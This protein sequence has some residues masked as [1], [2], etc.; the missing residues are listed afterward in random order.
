MT[1][2]PWLEAVEGEAWELYFYNDS[3]PALAVVKR[4]LDP[5]SKDMTYSLPSSLVFTGEVYNNLVVADEIER[6]RRIWP[7]PTPSTFLDPHPYIASKLI[8]GEM[9]TLARGDSRKT[10]EGYSIITFHP[11]PQYE[12]NQVYYRWKALG[13]EVLP[14]DPKPYKFQGRG[15][16]APNSDRSF[17]PE[18]G[19]SQNREHY[20]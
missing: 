4:V 1:N 8:D 20:A 15:F 16:V 17:A 12:Q 2:K 18:L 6:G 9:K 14:L 13:R 3:R 5:H 7:A 10:L 11:E 19:Y